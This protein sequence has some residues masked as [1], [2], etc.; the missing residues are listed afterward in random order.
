MEITEV[1]KR[2]QLYL[3]CEEDLGDAIL[4]EHEDVVNLREQELLRMIKQLVI[5]TVSVVVRRYFLSTRQDLTENT[6]T[7]GACL[8]GK[9]GLCSHTFTRPKD[10]CN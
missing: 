4:K 5:I 9:A 10:G 3:C 6:R 8:K 7:F 1:E 2:R